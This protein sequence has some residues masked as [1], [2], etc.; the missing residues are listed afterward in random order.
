MVRNQAHALPEWLDFH[1]LQGVDLFVFYDNN[2]TDDTRA[3]LGAYGPLVRTVA[4]AAPPACAAG[5]L[6]ECQELAFND[7]VDSVRDRTQWVG[8]F[9]VDEFLFSTAGRLVDALDPRA[10]GYEFTGYQF[11]TNGFATAADHGQRLVL[12]NYLYRAPESGDPAS[13]TP[14][15]RKTVFNPDKVS[16]V[17]IHT[18]TRKWWAPQL[19][20]VYAEDGGPLRLHHY[21]HKSREDWAAKKGVW[22]PHTAAVTAEDDEWDRRASSVYDNTTFAFVERVK[23]AMQTRVDAWG[24][25][26]REAMAALRVLAPGGERAAGRERRAR[27]GMLAPIGET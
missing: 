22:T 13:P 9:D 1:V 12:E 21:P 24:V 8:V 3:V 18:F 20:C 16:H 17:E 25:A 15:V 26:R 14:G 6:S 7:C 19:V 23:Q 27:D 2:S 5:R 11:G 10:T 4:W